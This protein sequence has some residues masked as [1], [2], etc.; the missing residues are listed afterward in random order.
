MGLLGISSK[1]LGL[2]RLEFL[3]LGVLGLFLPILGVQSNL[4]SG[5]HIPGLCFPGPM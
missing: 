5:G 3:E 2:L 1:G 4:L